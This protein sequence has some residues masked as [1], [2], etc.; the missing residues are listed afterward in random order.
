M[1]K[2]WSMSS[3][4]IESCGFQMVRGDKQC[5]QTMAQGKVKVMQRGRNKQHST[6][7]QE[8]ITSSQRTTGDS[9]REITCGY[10]CASYHPAVPLLDLYGRN[11]CRQTQGNMHKDNAAFE[12]M[13]KN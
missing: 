3:K 5:I 13:S 4:K 7:G 9:M 11:S 8:N 6:V 2:P 1:N 12:V 10:R